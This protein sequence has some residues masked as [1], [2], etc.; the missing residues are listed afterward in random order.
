MPVGAKK[1][2]FRRSKLTRG[3]ICR[4]PS[5]YCF[6]LVPWQLLAF[7][8]STGPSCLERLLG[9]TM[10][11]KSSFAIPKKALTIERSW[12]GS[13]AREHPQ[14]PLPG[15]G[16]GG[17]HLEEQKWGREAAGWL[18]PSQDWPIY[19]AN[20]VIGPHRCRLLKLHLKYLHTAF[21]ITRSSR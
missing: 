6:Q 7:C 18:A 2:Q 14:P 12:F 10:G 1:H 17:S 5:G 20:K 11:K 4:G 16:T 3:A 21:L 19:R 13:R 8:S 9:S 15:T